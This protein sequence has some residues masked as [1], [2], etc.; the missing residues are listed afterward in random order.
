MALLP[1]MTAWALKVGDEFTKS[2]WSYKVT[3]EYEV[4]VTGYS[5]SQRDVTI[6]D[7]V[8]YK[9]DIYIVVGIGSKAFDGNTTLQSVTIPYG[10]TII[11]WSAFKTVRV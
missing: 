2:P 9:S 6:P 3:S 11:D 1:S 4:E 5:G 7:E 8:T 10:V